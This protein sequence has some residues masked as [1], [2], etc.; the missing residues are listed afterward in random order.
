MND[1]DDIINVL[2]QGANTLGISLPLGSVLAFQTYYELLEKKGREVN[3]TTIRGA[4]DV[5]RLHFLDSLCLMSVVDFCNASVIDVGSGAGFPGLPLK[6]AQPTIDLT[7]LD[8]S[9]KRVSFLTA[10]CTAIKIEA[11]CVH[12]RAEEYAHNLSVRERY[13]V[14]VSRAVANL[15]VLAEL[16]LPMVCTGGVFLA[17]KSLGAKDEIDE[18]SS[19][20]ETLGAKVHRQVDYVIPG[21]DITHTVVEIRKIASTPIKYP[22]RF[23]RIQKTPL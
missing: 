15:S 8:A 19:A 16:C 18:A 12:A 14:A 9:G 21:T 4:T 11:K 5:A 22:R 1:K 20:I 6:I 2:M 23:A 10:L 13:D 7:L 3:L 17:M